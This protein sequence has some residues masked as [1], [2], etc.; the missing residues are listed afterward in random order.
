MPAVLVDLARVPLD[1]DLVHRQLGQ[2]APINKDRLLRDQGIRSC[3]SRRA[4]FQ[5]RSIRIAYD[6]AVT[7]IENPA[8]KVAELTSKLG[9]RRA[10]Q[11][12]QMQQEAEDGAVVCDQ[13][14]GAAPQA[15][16]WR[17]ALVAK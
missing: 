5:A 8:A 6:G 12:Q 1:D 4:G 9:E 17:W 2:G 16:T 3:T 11:R 15:A 7:T 13:H 14:G 10:A